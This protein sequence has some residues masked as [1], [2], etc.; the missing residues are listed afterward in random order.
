MELNHHRAGAGEPLVLL[1]GIGSHW[2]MWEP[3][4]PAL[5]ARHEVIAVDLPGFGDSPMPPP[6]TPPGIDSVCVWFDDTLRTIMPWARDPSP[7]PTVPSH[8]RLGRQGS[9]PISA[10]GPAG[11]RG[12]PDREARA[13]DRLRA[14]ADV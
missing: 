11:G 3:V 2:Q 7:D 14:P 1:H 9:A 6:G 5:T 12:D 13:A 8:D 10:A 4:L